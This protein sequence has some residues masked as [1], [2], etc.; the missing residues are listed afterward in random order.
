MR[1]CSLQLLDIGSVILL[2][3]IF[4]SIQQKGWHDNAWRHRRMI[5]INNKANSSE[6]VGLMD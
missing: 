4:S 1:F 6:L 5:T 3:G 2:A